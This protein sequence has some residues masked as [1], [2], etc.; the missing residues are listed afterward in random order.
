M[1][2]GCLLETVR[3]DL[4]DPSRFDL[5]ADRLI[6]QRTALWYCWQLLRLYAECWRVAFMP[7]FR[8]RPAERTQMFLTDLRF[9]VRSFRREPGFNILAMLTLALGIGSMTMMYSVVYN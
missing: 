2:A 7:E 4:F 1:L 6:G 3:R 5:R 9:A 8:P